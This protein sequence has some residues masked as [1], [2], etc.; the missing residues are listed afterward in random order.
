M[1]TAVDNKIQAAKPNYRMPNV[2]GQIGVGYGYNDVAKNYYSF[3]ISATNFNWAF[4]MLALGDANHFGKHGKATY[5]TMKCLDEMTASG[6]FAETKQ[7]LLSNMAG[8]MAFVPSPATNLIIQAL[9]DPG[10]IPDEYLNSTYDGEAL[11]SPIYEYDGHTYQTKIVGTNVSD[12]M[13]EVQLK[14]D[15]GNFATLSQ[16]TGDIIAVLDWYSPITNRLAGYAR[17]GSVGAPQLINNAVQTNKIYDNAIATDK[18]KNAA[19]SYLKLASNVRETLIRHFSYALNNT[20]YRVAYGG[21]HLKGMTVEGLYSNLTTTGQAPYPLTEI[22]DGQSNVSGFRIPYN[23]QNYY[24]LSDAKLYG[25][26]YL[27]TDSDFYECP[28]YLDKNQSN[29]YV[30]V[31][32]MRSTEISQHLTDSNAYLYIFIPIQT[33][34]TPDFSS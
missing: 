8:K 10:E 25:T 13:F 24:T 30:E 20:V 28:I 11:V 15:D 22:L 3:N 16:I 26:C 4:L 29:S 2:N 6:E 23:K 33:D 32:F 27:K 19:V 21:T 5:T 18:I 34:K 14:T 9:V 1:G 12:K 17:E 7:Y 31:F